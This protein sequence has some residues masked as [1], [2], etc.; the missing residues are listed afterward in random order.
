MSF[1]QFVF[2]VFAA[3]SL[4]GGLRMITVNNSVKAALYLV[5]TFISTAAIWVM[6][7]AEFLGI[8]LILV[9]VGAVMVLFLFVVMMLDINQD[10]KREGFAS[11]LP[12]GILV[13][14][15]VLI[16]IGL[17]LGPRYFGVLDLPQPVGLSQEASNTQALGALLY[18]D[19]VYAVELAAILLLVGIVAAIILV[20]RRRDLSEI[21]YQDISK[22]VK[23]RAS[24][25]FKMVSMEAEV[26]HHQTAK[27]PVEEAK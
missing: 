15:V 24:E 5:M 1:E 21:K 17:V 16:E 27:A 14:V 8:V 3:V 25:R 13:A 6:L 22:Q 2:Y 18:T 10:P 20:F 23:A 7:N 12:T 19:Y 11:Y 4:I 9:Y 26:S